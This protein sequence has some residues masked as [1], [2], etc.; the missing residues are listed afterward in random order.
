[1]IDKKYL[2]QLRAAGLHLSPPVPAFYNGVW[3][4]KPKNVPGHSFPGPHSGYVVIGDDVPE[5][6]EID[7]P[8]LM[9]Y[10]W[11]G[12][13]VVRGQECVPSPGP[14]DFQNAWQNPED[15]ISDILD[16]FFGDPTRMEKKAVVN[17]THLR[18]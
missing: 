9:F 16:F 6:P 2:D 13:W 17:G 1:M 3:V 14:A 8:M 18:R 15:A 11:D 10:T 7:A 5:P 12:E 4:C